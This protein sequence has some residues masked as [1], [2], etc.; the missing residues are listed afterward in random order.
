MIPFKTILALL[1]FLILSGCS[2]VAPPGSSWKSTSSANRNNNTI[3]TNNS[4]NS[5][6]PTN[7]DTGTGPST[8]SADVG[9]AIDTT[10]NHKWSISPIGELEGAAYTVSISG[11]DARMLYNVTNV[12]PEMSTDLSSGKPA[13]VAIKKG[14]RYTC[15]RN[16][17]RQ[18]HCFFKINLAD[19]SIDVVVPA[20][21]N[22]G[23]DAEVVLRSDYVSK[24]TSV[25]SLS[26]PKDSSK[27]TTFTLGMSKFAQQIYDGMNHVSPVETPAT[28]TQKVITNKSGKNIMCTNNANLL[29]P[30]SCNLY[31]DYT[32]GDVNMVYAPKP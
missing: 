30:Y 1:I 18:Y 28:A 31:L 5:T 29:Y 7:P 24:D 15:E 9:T 10:P 8:N 22:G 12:I 19:G 21:P 2:Q 4:G 3:L 20:D 13:R 17:H 32:T 11:V 27:I 26:I 14:V 6:S 25:Q 23:F 16:A